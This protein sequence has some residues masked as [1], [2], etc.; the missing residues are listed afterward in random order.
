MH[1]VCAVLDH[2]HSIPEQIVPQEE[3]KGTKKF[4]RVVLQ[5][6]KQADDFAK[7]MP[8]AAQ[9]KWQFSR[10]PPTMKKAPS[11][12]HHNKK[13]QG[14]TQ[15]PEGSHSSATINLVSLNLSLLF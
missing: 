15:V 7:R 8:E 2:S 9:M 13:S 12:V 6:Q 1:H 11:A 4:V 3:F 5:S 14:I 10:S